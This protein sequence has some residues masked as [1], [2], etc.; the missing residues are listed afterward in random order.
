MILKYQSKE[1]FIELLEIL[2]EC[3]TQD[4][5][6]TK[7]NKRLIVNNSNLLDQLLKES[8][9]VFYINESSRKGIILIWKSF[10]GDKERNFV[11]LIAN[12]VQT[13]QDLITILNWVHDKTLFVK[14]KKT[15]P[16][17][18]IFRD[19]GDFCF[20]GGR[21]SEILLIKEKFITERKNVIP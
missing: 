11:K 8:Y 5:Y 20:S 21:G 6:L 14:I 9:H 10:G 16:F 13:A 12:N 2:S 17:L 7:N 1:D 19:K 3:D 4:F 18:S 15:S